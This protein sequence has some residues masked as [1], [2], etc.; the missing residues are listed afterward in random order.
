MNL[1]ETPEMASI[2]AEIREALAS[3]LPAGWQGSGFL[4]MDVRPEHMEIARSLEKSL[5]SKKLLAPAWPAEYG[6]RG[7]SPKEQFALFEELGYALAPRLTTISV[8]L[9]GP[10]LIHYGSEEQRSR[11]L[12]AIANDA[13]VWSQGFSEP[14]AGSDLTGLQTRA[15]RIGD[16][17]TVNGTKIW[18]SMVHVSD[19]II[20][21]ARTGAP[22]SRGRGLS[23]FLVPTDSPGIEVRPLV[24]ATDQHML[25]QVFFDNVQVPVENRIGEENEGWRYATTLLQYER[26]DALLVGQFR[27]MLDDLRRAVAAAPGRRDA[28]A[29]RRVLAQCEIEL[30]IGRLFTLRVVDAYVRGRVPDTEASITKLYMTEAFQRLGEAARSLAGLYSSLTHRDRLSPLGGRIANTV[31]ASTTGTIMGGTSEIQR[32]IIATRG[33]GLPRG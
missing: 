32:T 2:R 14:G 20:L 31:V 4:P 30:Q 15:E 1:H 7:L 22:D 13:V 18:T 6:G 3:G 10:V 8:D 19:W 25:N 12:S 33:L 27:R 17:Y 24:D 5:A 16:T 11:H 21:L 26:G 9:V 23:L 29:A 28:A